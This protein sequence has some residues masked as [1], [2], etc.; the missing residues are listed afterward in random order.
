[1]ATKILQSFIKNLNPF[2]RILMR[3]I[4]KNIGQSSSP[5][6][7]PKDIA[8]I[9]RILIC[10]P[11]HRLGNLLL[12]T[13][14]LEEITAT[15]PYCTIDL[16][17][18]GPL[19]PILFKNYENIDIIIQLPKKPFSHPIQYLQGWKSIRKHKYDL[20]INVSKSSSSGR[21]ST[22][23]A[24]SKYKIFGDNIHNIS[25]KDYQHMAKNPVY[26]LK[27]F[28]SISGYGADDTRIPSLNIK[29]SP[30]EID[31][32]EL[33]LK[34]LTDNY[35][36]TICLYT[37]ATGEKCYT[38]EWW[39]IFY[40]RLKWEYPDYNIIEVLPVENVSNIMYQAPAFYST[41]LRQIAA[42]IANTELCIGADSG[43]MHLANASQTATV[44][45]FS[46]TDS[47]RYHPYGNSSLAINTN[48]LTLDDWFAIVNSVLDSSESSDPFEFDYDSLEL[49]S[50]AI[51]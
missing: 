28:L 20:V 38:Q 31:E 30:S 8:N 49:Q 18:K 33:I 37:Y 42:L 41:N 3:T 19:A 35:K 6:T 25:N 4:T 43:I 45:L 5:I 32:G 40:D 23:F 16:F 13:P 29:L 10:R 39:A 26:N 9:K 46:V 36:K 21:L 51:F 50:Y 1:M 15:F 12:L 7:G 11:N 34:K 22:Q 14:L 47:S 48:D 27:H 44:G 17:V 2:R 24:K